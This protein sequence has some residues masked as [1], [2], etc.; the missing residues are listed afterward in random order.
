MF[1][2]PEKAEFDAPFGP[3]G[4]VSAQAYALG[5]RI[6]H[7]T[8]IAARDTRFREV[9]PE[10]CFYAM[11]DMRRLSYKKK[12]ARGALERLDPLRRHGINIE[13]DALG[14]SATVALD[15]LLDASA[16][17]W[18]ARRRDAVPQPNPL[19]KKDGMEVAIW[20]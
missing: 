5:D 1:A 17:A 16:A 2:I 6:R 3:G 14:Q 18:T 13:R 19:E 9:H 7:V 4:G 11:N 15:D 8:A 12:T 10:L 20:Y